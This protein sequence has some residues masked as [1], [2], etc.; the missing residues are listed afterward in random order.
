MSK[1]ILMKKT[2]CDMAKHIAVFAAVLFALWLLLFLSA[3]IPNG[4][5]RDNMIESALTY[6]RRP[7]FEFTDEGRFNAVADHYAD[8]IWLNVAWNIGEGNPL[9]SSIQTNY[10]D[11]EELGVNAG[12][13][14]TVAEGDKPNRDYSRYWHGTAAFIRLLHL[15]CNVDGIKT[16]GFIAFLMLAG[17][18][19]FMLARKKHWDIAVILAL[20]L[21]AVQIWNIRL[22]MEYQPSFILAFMLIPAYLALERKG[23][24]RL[25]VLCVVSGTMTAFF[26]FLTTETV[27]V[28]LPLALVVAVR[29]K[30][31][32]LGTVKESLILLLKCGISWAGA[33][34]GA[35]FVKWIIAGF[36][37]GSGSFSSALGYAGMHM[38]GGDASAIDAQN[39]PEHFFSGLLANLTTLLGGAARIEAARVAIGLLI[40]AFAVLL[41]WCIFCR[42]GENRGAATLLMMLGAVVFVRFIALN[43]HSYVHEFFVYRALVSPIFALL[44]AVWLNAGLPKKWRRR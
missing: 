17:L 27:T 43:N 30:E 2:F 13:Y 38:L 8:T 9:V 35:F 21:I 20:S 44:S 39:R 15:F 4:A 42:K 12:F 23:D 41:I 3:L 28:L 6:E 22:S 31:K 34:A 29:A 32:R 36:V 18:S 1:N 11:G 19:L 26:D 5:I 40:C 14:Y 25:T 24:G 33:Y 16:I 7:A 37:S 10:Y